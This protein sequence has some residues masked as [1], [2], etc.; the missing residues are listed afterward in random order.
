MKGAL[1]IIHQKT[2]PSDPKKEIFTEMLLQIGKIHKIVQ[3]LLSYAR[4]KEINIS[5]IDPNECVENANKLA[6]P[7]TN[8]KNIHLHSKVLE[9]GS[10]DS[11]DAEKIQEWL[12]NMMQNSI[13]ATQ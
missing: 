8:K 4:P 7:Q 3:V 2:G 11:L 1:E 12:V 13:Y 5:L 9:D 6:K 10:L